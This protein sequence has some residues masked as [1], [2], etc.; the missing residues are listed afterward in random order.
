MGRATA[1]KGKERRLL[2]YKR[3]AARL[4]AQDW[5]AVAIELAL[6]VTGVFIGIQVSNWNDDRKEQALERA[7]LARIAKI[8]AAMSRTLTR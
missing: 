4:Q 8:F 1:E 3:V 5:V 2:I 7:S 6:I